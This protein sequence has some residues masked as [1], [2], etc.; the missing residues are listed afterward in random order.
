MA[1]P[2]RIKFP[3]AVYHIT[4]RGNARQNIFL[5]DADRRLFLTVLADV[6][7]KY[8]WQCYSYCLMNNHYH[9]L[10]ET[11]E[12]NLSQSMRQ[13]NGVYTQTFNRNHQRVGHV[14]Q[15]RYKAILVEKDSY[16]LMLCRYI[17]MNPVRAKMVLKP[18]QW[19]W[20]SYRAT[21]GQTRRPH[22]LNTEWILSQFHKNESE[23][24]RQ[25]REFMIEQPGEKSPWDNVTG[26]ILLG[27]GPF[28]EQTK[29][30]WIDKAKATEVPRIQRLTGRPEL[31]DIFRN[32]ETRN[33]RN[34]MIVKAH[35]TFEYTLTEIG[36]HVD[37]HYSTVSRLYTKEKLKTSKYKT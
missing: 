34:Q 17:V 37:L 8:R 11:T 23:A 30:L 25:Y 10:I 22:F 6:V 16:L 28:I 3:G 5:N 12:G 36:Q 32:K 18:E 33:E 21:T 7:E 19:H 29:G 35:E 31:K 13:L 20:S 9:L 26:Q 14:F 4:S 27:K 24:L 2:L 15:G 1:R